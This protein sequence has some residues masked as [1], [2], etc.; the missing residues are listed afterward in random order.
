MPPTV[1]ATT[2]TP[3]PSASASCCTMARMRAVSVA[4]FSDNASESVRFT[5][6]LI[7]AR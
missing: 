4:T 6:F 1:N 3:R 5:V 7:T 2:S